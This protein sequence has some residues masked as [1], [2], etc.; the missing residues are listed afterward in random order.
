[1]LAK[2]RPF[3][4]FFTLMISAKSC[5][6]LM[7]LMSHVAIPC[8]TCW[9]KTLD[10][11]QLVQS[12]GCLW[13]RFIKWAHI[14]T[15]IPHVTMALLTGASYQEMPTTLPASLDLRGGRVTGWPFGIP[16]GYPLSTKARVSYWWGW[17]C[18]VNN[19]FL[20]SDTSHISITSIF[21]WFAWYTQSKKGTFVSYQ[22][23]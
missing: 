20:L 16:V 9:W 7:R 10:K 19:E 3:S 2:F 21:S 4:P 18:I 15:R 11:I 12:E 14:W 17:W 5:K 22:V 1:M 6:I 23:F 8:W 13:N